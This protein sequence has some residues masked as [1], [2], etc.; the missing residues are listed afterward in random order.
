MLKLTK[1][2]LLDTLRDFEAVFWPLVFPIILFFILVSVFGGMGTSNPVRFKLGILQRTQLTGFGKIL[3]NVIEQIQPDP[4]HVVR[5]EDLSQALKDLQ[6]DRIQLL[7]EIP[8]TFNMDLTRAILTSGRS[9]VSLKVHCLSGKM[10]SETAATILETILSTLNVE[11]FKRARPGNF[12][13]V[14]FQLSIVSKPNAH[15]FHYAT[16]LF[17][18][19]LLMAI[20]SFGFFH[21][22]LWLV[23]NRTSGLNKRLYASPVTPA[24]S[25]LSLG[26]AQLI[27]MLVSCLLIYVFGYFVYNVSSSIFSWSFILTLLFSMLVSLSMGLFLVCLFLK[28]ASAVV[29]GQVLYQ[30]MMFVG[31]LYFPVLR[32]N[33]PS[34]LKYFA[35]A[36]PSTHLAEL[37]RSALGHSVY[38]LPV[39]QMWSIPSLWLI[40]S[41]VL[42]LIRFKWVMGYE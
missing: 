9:N 20:M 15:S 19:I 23:F 3:E 17:P 11:I 40:A 26:L 5:Y 6:S 12:T 39:W 30:I 18:G 29:S 33:V 25:L 4:F 1:G 28:P 13:E 32:Y 8:D 41:V 10:E 16:Y 21:L 38:S 2:I 7:L 37:L 36:L 35:L 42:F 14:N 24:K 31:G 22:P 34:F 27:V